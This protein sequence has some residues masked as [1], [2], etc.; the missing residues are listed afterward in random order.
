VIDMDSVQTLN[1]LLKTSRDGESGFRECA[2]Q[3]SSSQLR[4]VMEARAEECARAAEE[5]KAEILRLGGT[6]DDATSLP[7]DV[8]R[9]W[10]IARGALSGKDD[11]AILAECE[12]GEDV[13]LADYRVAI[14]KPLPPDVWQLVEHQLA[15]VQRN[16]DQV[17]A[18]RDSLARGSARRAGANVAIAAPASPGEGRS[19][20]GQWALAQV[21]LH[22]LRSFGIAAVAGVVGLYAM[23]RG[24]AQPIGRWLR[25]LR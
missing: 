23:S 21:R 1:L 10:V 17:K 14:E 20:V 15:G 2:R 13:A 9:G 24:R 6:A 7:G 11:H 5:L 18:L 12:R 22:P 16:H 19:R 4:S 8:H 3:L 25:G